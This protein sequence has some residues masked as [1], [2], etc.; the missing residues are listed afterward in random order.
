MQI[1]GCLY[2]FRNVQKKQNF[3]KMSSECFMFHYDEEDI[4]H[5]C[6]L[7]FALNEE[8]LKMGMIMKK[9]MSYLK[10]KRTDF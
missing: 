2:K 3:K 8:G 1:L 5:V 4:Y 7:V 9:I 10:N 6:N